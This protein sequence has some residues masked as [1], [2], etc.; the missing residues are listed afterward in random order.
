MHFKLKFGVIIPKLKVDDDIFDIIEKKSGYQRVT[1]KERN[2]ER[3]RKAYALL[4]Q[5]KLGVNHG[6]ED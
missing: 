3:I 6:R 4:K 2:L 5:F 1:E